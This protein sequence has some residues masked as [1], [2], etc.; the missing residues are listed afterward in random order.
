M[1]GRV[2]SAIAAS[3][4]GFECSTLRPHHT[5]GLSSPGPLWCSWR[6][7]RT[8]APAPFRKRLDPS[9][10]GFECSALRHRPAGTH[11]GGGRVAQPWRANRTGVPGPLGRRR[12]GPE[13]MGIVSSA[14]RPRSVRPAV[15]DTCLSRRRSRVRIPYGVP[16]RPPPAV[17]RCQVAQVGRALGCYPSGWGF[18]A[19]PGSQPD[20]DRRAACSHRLVAQDTGLSLRRHGFESRWEYRPVRVRLAVTR[21]SPSWYG[22]EL[23]PR[24]K[25]GSSPWGRTTPTVVPGRCNWMHVRLWIGR[26]EVRAL[27]PEPHRLPSGGSVL[28][29]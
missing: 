25:Q 4:V 2:A 1:P 29:M 17:D 9:G 14:L 11:R 7:N 20:V 15:Q 8:G 19:L 24:N 18:E 3:A 21:F 13:P 5:P 23:L 26:L 16:R 22:T 28:W 27:P 6:A 10:L 12:V